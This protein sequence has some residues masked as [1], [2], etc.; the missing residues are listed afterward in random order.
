M[1]RGRG[2]DRSAESGDDARRTR[3]GRPEGDDRAA[4]RGANVRGPATV[5]GWA[6]RRTHRED[7]TA[8]TAA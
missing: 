8:W 4:D 2:E 3:R 1:S 7:Q 6:R 5:R